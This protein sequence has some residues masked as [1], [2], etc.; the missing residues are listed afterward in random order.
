VIVGSLARLGALCNG[1]MA[2]K[3]VLIV[4]RGMGL[5]KHLL[6]GLGSRLRQGRALNRE[7]HCGHRDRTLRVKRLRETSVVPEG[8]RVLFPLNPALRFATCW[9]I[10]SPRLRRSGFW[11][12]YSTSRRELYTLKPRPS[13]CAAPEGAQLLKIEPTQHSPTPVRPN[14][15]TGDLAACWA[16]LSPSR[17]AGLDCG[18]I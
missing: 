3:E 10:M 5:G 6:R 9:A 7:A 1:F 14:R 4:A 8:L 2:R 11:T 12:S 15:R 18:Y 17:F 16:I 13:I